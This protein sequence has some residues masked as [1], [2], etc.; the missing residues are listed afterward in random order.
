M[1]GAFAYEFGAF[2]EDDLL[3]STALPQ[4]WLEVAIPAMRIDP[5]LY[6]ASGWNDNSFD[7]T[8]VRAYPHAPRFSF[9]EATETGAHGL[10]FQSSEGVRALVAQAL[11]RARASSQQCGRI[12]IAIYSACVQGNTTLKI[13]T[14]P[15]LASNHGGVRQGAPDTL[16]GEH[17]MGLGWLMPHVVFEHTLGRRWAQRWASAQDKGVAPKAWDQLVQG[18]MPAGS[19]CLYPTVALT[20]HRRAEGPRV[21][22]AAD[23]DF[24]TPELLDFGCAALKKIGHCN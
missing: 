15:N 14:G 4:Y 8:A 9:K 22:H 6:C 10:S 23:A 7:A 19:E 3:V 17:F 12:R 11:C 5:T 13:S 21:R 2:V 20:H 1:F 24:C 16:R 18:A